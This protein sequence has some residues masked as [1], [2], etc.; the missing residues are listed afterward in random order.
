MKVEDD[1]HNRMLT[2]RRERVPLVSSPRRGE[3]RGSGMKGA[4]A[5]ICGELAPSSTPSGHLFPG[6]EKKRAATPH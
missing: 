6:G 3:V 1:T 2:I 4:T 5:E